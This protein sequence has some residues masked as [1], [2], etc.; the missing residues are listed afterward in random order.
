MA[1]VDRERCYCVPSVN[2]ALLFVLVVIRGYLLFEVNGEIDDE[3]SI[4]IHEFFLHLDWDFICGV[5]IFE[6][7]VWFYE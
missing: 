7:S 1:Q 2:D 6:N 4:S 3:L 5:R